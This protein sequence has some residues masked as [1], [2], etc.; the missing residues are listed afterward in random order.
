MRDLT[1]KI[2]AAGEVGCGGAG[3]PTH[4]KMAKPA[5]WFIVNG[6]E[7]EPLLR[8]DRAVLLRHTSEIVKTVD[9]IARELGAER[10]GIALKE[11]YHNE[12][13]ALSAAIRKCGSGA[14]LFR[15]GQFYPAGDEQVIVQQVT[16]MTVPPA[17]IPLERGVVVSN[18]AT[19]LA[20]HDALHG[21]P[22]THKIVT[23]TGADAKPTLIRMPVGT[24]VGECLRLA[25]G[26]TMERFRVIEG[27]PLMGKL[28]AAGTENGHPVGKT[29]SGL[30][31]VAHDSYLA[32]LPEISVRH[33]VNRARSACIQCSYC[34]MLCPRYLTGHSLQ[35]HRIMRKL[36]YGGGID[37]I[38]DDEDARQAALCCECGVCE[39]YACPMSLQPRRVNV[40][41]KR[42][43]AES[44]RKYARKT[45][46][47]C[48]ARPEFVDRKVPTKRIAARAGVLEYYNASPDGI[49]EHTP[50]RIV[51]PLKQHIGAAALPVVA[52]GDPVVAGQ[53]L[54]ACPEGQ[55]GA[56]IHSGIGGVVTAVDAGIVIEREPR[57][58]RA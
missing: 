20:V 16:G 7:C 17:G 4:V 23:V 36:A 1:E 33:T 29:T 48:S 58:S 21:R 24:A 54:A 3:F 35:P 42:K 55:L 9:T 50:D 30:V 15:L 6:V 47:T 27:G 52:A 43:F 13:D 11:S 2:F 34:T 18:A 53:L 39:I 40:L 56:H 19:V 51:V 32:T 26:P 37:E 49:I 31:V 57:C 41:L 44:G 8:T 12:I 14:E 28:I 46:E 10:F 22:L 45:A 5:A 25:G 38:L